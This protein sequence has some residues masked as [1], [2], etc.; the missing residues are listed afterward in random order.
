MFTASKHGL[1]PVEVKLG[2]IVTT[3]KSPS[4]KEGHVLGNFFK[5]HYDCNPWII[6]FIY[7]LILVLE[8]FHISS[9]VC[10]LLVTISEKTL[11]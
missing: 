6:R 11:S 5:F 7:E 1:S 9:P 3:R 2:E 4:F 8:V 10:P